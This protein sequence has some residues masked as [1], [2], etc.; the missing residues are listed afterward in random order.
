VNKSRLNIVVT[1]A[2]GLVGSY[3]V[4]RLLD[5]GYRR[6]IGLTRTNSSRKLVGDIEGDIQ[7]AAGDIRDILTVD[8]ALRGADYVIHTAG[9]VSFD[10]AEEREMY[11]VN[12]RGTAQVVNACL[13]HGVKKLIH[14]SSVAALGRPEGQMDLDEEV[15]WS[16]SP[17]NTPYA[18]SKYAAELE[19]FRGEAEGLNVSIIQ[20]GTILGSGDWERGSVRLIKGVARGLPF[21][22]GGVNGFV[23]VRDVAD[24]SIRLM[25]EEEL[26]GR[27]I[28]CSE[29]VSYAYLLYEM[30][31]YLGSSAPKWK[32]S[33]PVANM[34]IFFDNLRNKIGRKPRFLTQASYRVGQAKYRY[35][36]AKVRTELG[37]RFIPL[38]ETLR[39]SCEAFLAYEKRGVFVPLV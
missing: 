18:R 1:G 26:N 24:I 23:D 11:Q 9:K 6:I 31:G 32:L 5:R 21:Y 25:E 17:N 7:W 13:K 22:P 15:E 37:Y 4:R 8:E 34:A 2:T 14:V 30:A 16:A 33:T 38:G 3:V 27:W 35:E 28:A 12:V 36:N 29:S 10:P 20:P 19:V 39:Q